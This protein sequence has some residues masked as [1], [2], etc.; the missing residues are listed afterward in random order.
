MSVSGWL[1]MA[2]KNQRIANFFILQNQVV[3]LLEPA[4]YYTNSK[5]I[6]TTKI[7]KFSKFFSRFPIDSAVPVANPNCS[8]YHRDAYHWDAFSSRISIGLVY[9]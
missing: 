4:F 8:V 5:I 9:L 1:Y 2:T 6:F 3:Y 7:V